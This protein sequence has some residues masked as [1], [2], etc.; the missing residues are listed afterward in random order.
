[1]DFL[2]QKFTALARKLRTELGDL[3]KAF[4]DIK[5][6]LQKQNQAIAIATEAY[7][8]E[9]GPTPEMRAILNAL[10][11]IK[12][13]QRN[14]NRSQTTYQRR[15]LM[16]AWAGVFIVLAYTTA[17]FVQDW[18]LNDTIGIQQIAAKE[19]RIQAAASI[20]AA[21]AAV[22]AAQTASNQF[23][24][25]RH[26]VETTDAASV[27][28]GPMY[29]GLNTIVVQVNNGGLRYTRRVHG[30]ITV[31][32][33]FKDTGIPNGKPVHKPFT[34]EQLK[35]GTEFSVEVPWLSDSSEDIRKGIQTVI[36]SGK[37]TYDDGFGHIIPETTCYETVPQGGGY[38]SA[39]F[40]FVSCESS[41]HEFDVWKKNYPH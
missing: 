23:G 28:L 26:Q 18:L 10:E 41:T 12:T 14:S 5:E 29:Q 8:K 22:L 24:L 16:V 4:S 1:M 15:N 2:T 33:K 31:T 3:K 35:G 37:W 39:N 32:R 36:F 11:E 40:D 13:E 38:P 17:A 30:E 6:G 27:T 34:F 9:E 25:V 20:R 19:E 7:Q 21:N